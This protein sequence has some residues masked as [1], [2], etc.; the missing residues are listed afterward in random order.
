MAL[1]ATARGIKFLPVDI[2]L[3]DATTFVIEGDLVSGSI[4]LPFVA[5][6][7]LG[8][9]AAVSIKQARDERPFSSKDDVLNRSRL[10]K[11]LFELFDTMG[12]FGDLPEHDEEKEKGLF[13]FDFS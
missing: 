1:E 9:S 7:G 6:D 3:S 2:N 4:R 10:N 13:A 11:S 12:A 5:V 8:E